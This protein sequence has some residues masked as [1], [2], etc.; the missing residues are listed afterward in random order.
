MKREEEPED[1]SREQGKGL[2]FWD[3]VGGGGG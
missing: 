3:G 2:G 1:M